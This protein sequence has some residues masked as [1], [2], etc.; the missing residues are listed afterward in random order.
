MVVQL[1]SIKFHDGVHNGLPGRGMGTTA[2]KAKLT[3]SLVWRDQCP[4]YQIYLN[5]RNAYDALDRE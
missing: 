5:L 2:I 3:Q 1:A 4:L